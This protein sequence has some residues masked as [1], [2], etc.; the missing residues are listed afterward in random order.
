MLFSHIVVHISYIMFPPKKRL[1]LPS[2]LQHT[3]NIH[4]DTADTVQQSEAYM[5][6]SWKKR[7]TK[8]KKFPCQQGELCFC[9]AQTKYHSEWLFN[10]NPNTQGAIATGTRRLQDVGGKQGGIEVSHHVLEC[11]ANWEGLLVTNRS[12]FKRLGETHIQSHPKSLVNLVTCSFYISFCFST[13]F[14]F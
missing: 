14:S 2:I 10:L 1:A 13:T 9:P 4:T 12:Y 7:K 6:P 5:V 8:S 3:Y 11:H